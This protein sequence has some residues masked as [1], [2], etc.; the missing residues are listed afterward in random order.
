V[1]AALVTGLSRKTGIA[2]AVAA[3]LARDG[4]TVFGTGWRPFDATESWG[5]HPEDAEELRAE[6][7]IAAWL[8]EDLSQPG[9]AVRMLDA[10]EAAVGQLTALVNA[11]THSSEGGFLETAGEDFDRHMAVNA[12]S[13]LLLGAEFARRF[14]GEHGSGRIVNYTSSAIVGELG[15]GASKAAIERITLGAA[16]ELAPRGITVNAVEPGPTDTG[17]M[18]PELYEQIL[19]SMPLGRIGRPADSAELVAFLCSQR[20]GWITGQIVYCD[21]GASL[22]HVIRR[23]RQPL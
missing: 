19:A 5:A 15:Y 3:S 6:G 14:R 13:T 2:A 18:S 4:W 23:G 10:A 12:R 8:E 22:P 11:H 21:G 1:P 9:A 16:Y 7:V 17:W 20:G